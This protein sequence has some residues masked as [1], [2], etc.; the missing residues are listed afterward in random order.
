MIPNSPR[1]RCSRREASM[2]PSTMSSASR[3]RPVQ[4]EL[5]S[6]RQ[7][8]WRGPCQAMRLRAQS[9]ACGANYDPDKNGL[10]PR[11]VEL[12]TLSMAAVPPSAA[13]ASATTLSMAPMVADGCQ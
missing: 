9:A 1:D 7:L 10:D 11:N 13:M 12:L 5:F 6:E 8:C 2:R 4:T 3:L